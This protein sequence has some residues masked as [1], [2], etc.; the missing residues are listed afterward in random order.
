MK[1]IL[2]MIV[3]AASILLQACV[4]AVV[5]V[6][7]AGSAL[8]VKHTSAFQRFYTD[9]DITNQAFIRI[10][11][12]HYLAGARILVATKNRNVLLIG[13]TPSPSQRLETER[14]I[15]SIPGV[16][17]IYNAIT[18]AGPTSSLTQSSDESDYYQN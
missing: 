12:D 7:V 4:P 14:L 10:K 17:R 5:G 18:I 13:Q 3:I 8:Y 9:T 15:Q 1:K 11:A 2:C 6:G 16:R